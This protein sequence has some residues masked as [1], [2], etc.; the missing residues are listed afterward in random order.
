MQIDRIQEAWREKG[1]HLLW[2]L[3]VVL[4]FINFYVYESYADSIDHMKR[5]RISFNVSLQRNEKVTALPHKLV[6]PPLEDAYER[7]RTISLSAEVLG[8]KA[9]VATKDKAKNG[10]KIYTLDLGS[11]ASTRNSSRQARKP[12]ASNSRGIV[13]FIRVVIEIP[14]TS[15]QQMISGLMILEDALKLAPLKLIK[16]ETGSKGLIAEGD[17]YGS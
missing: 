15:Y 11:P 6:M 4:F 12:M 5:E 14:I 9:N 7:L 16:I 2:L 17:L 3:V 8:I 13:R 10:Y 1:A